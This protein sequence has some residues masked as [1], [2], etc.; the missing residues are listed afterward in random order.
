MRCQA[1]LKKKIFIYVIV[2]CIAISA[3]WFIWAISLI[4]VYCY[5]P[6]AISRKWIFLVHEFIWYHKLKCMRYLYFWSSYQLT[7]SYYIYDLKIAISHKMYFVGIN[8]H[9]SKTSVLPAWDIAVNQTQR[10]TFRQSW[11]E[12]MVTWSWGLRT[13]S[14][15]SSST[16]DT[17]R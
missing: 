6:N 8:D 12:I 14:S 10:A 7:H 17:P 11:H 13:T 16:M 3:I 15:R 4:Y 9:V 2:T 1:N 5:V